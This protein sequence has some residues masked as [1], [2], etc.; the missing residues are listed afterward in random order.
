[1][2]HEMDKV[3]GFI[4]DLFFSRR[5]NPSTGIFSKEH[6]RISSLWYTF[7]IM[8]GAPNKHGLLANVYRTIVFRD[9][10]PP[11]KTHRPTQLCTLDIKP[12]VHLFS[13]RQTCIYCRESLDMGV[14]ADVEVS[15]LLSNK[16]GITT[17]TA[18]SSTCLNRHLDLS[19]TVQKKHILEVLCLEEMHHV[20]CQI[21]VM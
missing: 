10:S 13:T 15:D 6:I 16:T 20:E 18:C 1:M 14:R 11:D 8:T 9:I 12:H 7:R 5:N 2:H 21:S 19:I 4:R 17:L 3:R